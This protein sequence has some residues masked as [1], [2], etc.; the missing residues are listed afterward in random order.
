MAKQKMYNINNVGE[1]TF[2]Q[3]EKLVLED[4]LNAYDFKAKLRS[5]IYFGTDTSCVFFLQVHWKLLFYFFNF[6]K[7]IN[8]NTLSIS[9][10]LCN[11]QTLKS[12]L[13]S[14]CFTSCRLPSDVTW[15]IINSFYLH[16]KKIHKYQ[17]RK[18]DYVL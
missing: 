13:T 17:T 11:T 9:T 8:G 15:Q 14:C 2:C 12:S 3:L 5:E 16:F 1:L 7:V 4:I 18:D 10:A 6:F